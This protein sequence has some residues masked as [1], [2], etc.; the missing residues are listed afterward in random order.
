MTEVEGAQRQCLAWLPPWDAQMTNC[1]VIA[2]G[3]RG[4][5]SGCESTEQCDE[6]RGFDI[7]TPTLT[8]SKKPGAGP[9]R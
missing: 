3:E 9:P 4:G 2:E 1:L 7:Q 5:P 6:S 8:G